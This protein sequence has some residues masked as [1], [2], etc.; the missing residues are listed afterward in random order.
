[1]GGFIQPIFFGRFA[2]VV[3]VANSQLSGAGISHFLL[4]KA[5]IF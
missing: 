3:I 5:G 2:F 4:D 1:L